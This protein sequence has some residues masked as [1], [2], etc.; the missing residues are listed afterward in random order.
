MDNKDKSKGFLYPPHTGGVA[1]KSATYPETIQKTDTPIFS[2]PPKL[3]NYGG[4]L[5]RRWY[6][7][8]HISGTRHRVWIAA[9]PSETRAARAEKLLQQIKAGAYIAG[10]GGIMPELR[11]IAQAIDLRPKTRS[12]YLTAC[13]QFADFV[14]PFQVFRLSQVTEVQANAFFEHLKKRYSPVTVRNKLLSLKAI[15]SHYK[16]NPFDN[17]KANYSRK[18]SDF[19]QP[20]SDYE[21]A[22]IETYL[23]EQDERLFLFTRFIFYAFI[24]PKE[25][26]SLKV[27]D[28]DLRTRTI[29]VS[30]KVSK[31]KRSA[32]VP[33]IKPLFDL[34]LKHGLL[35]YPANFFLFGQNLK[36]GEKRA[37]MNEAN[38][39]HREALKALNLYRERETVLYSWKHTGNINLYLVKPDLKLLQ[40]MNRHAEVSTTEIYLRR[41]G[42][43]LNSAAFDVEY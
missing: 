28:I 34:I 6:I 13:K 20:F 9:K 26:I 19:N 1:C 4:D 18:D 5:T 22:E 32:A 23:Q 15:F 35:N 24:R 41:L 38:N 25:L 3:K 39:R 8:Y 2:K 12:T 21:R 33:I 43:F 14:S 36:P 40:Q 30:G 17:I 29:K 11:A 16:R 10:G 7:E 31:N 37:A 27:K 42:L